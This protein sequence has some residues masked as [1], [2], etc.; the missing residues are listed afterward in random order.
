MLI[1]NKV[2]FLK[3]GSLEKHF[4]TEKDRAMQEFGDKMATRG[5]KQKAC[6][7]K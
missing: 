6:F 4:T 3:S 7:L 5:R 2:K 1:Q